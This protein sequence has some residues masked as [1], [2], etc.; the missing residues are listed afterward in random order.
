MSKRI[1]SKSTQNSATTKPDNFRASTVY[2]HSPAK[3]PNLAT[4][5]FSPFTGKTRLGHAAPIRSA[6]LIQ[7]IL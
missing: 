6:Y 5:L 4:P 3:Q 2:Q 1:G 7:A